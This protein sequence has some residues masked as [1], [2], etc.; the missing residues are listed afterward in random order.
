VSLCLLTVA[1]VACVVPTLRAVRLDPAEVM[2][3]E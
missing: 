2:K 1:L 3:A